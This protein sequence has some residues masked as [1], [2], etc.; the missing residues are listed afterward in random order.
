MKNRYGDE[1]HWEK[2]SDKEYKFVMPGTFMDHC[3]FG[4]KE[5]QDSIDQDDLGF[6]DAS[7]GPFVSVGSKIYAD[8]ILGCYRLDDPLIVNRIRST[9]EGFTVEV[10]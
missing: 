7:G 8:E 4:G 9:E 6:F 1:Y 5:G 2:I 10:E 3:R